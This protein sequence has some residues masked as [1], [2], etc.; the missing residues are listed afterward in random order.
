MCLVAYKTPYQH[1]MYKIV[2]R[3][4]R[5]YL[6]LLIHHHQVKICQKNIFCRVPAG[7]RSAVSVFVCSEVYLLVMQLNGA[8]V[9]RDVAKVA[10]ASEMLTASLLVLCKKEVNIQTLDFVISF[11]FISLT[12]YFF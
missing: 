12:L 1:M 6:S 4:F 5:C 9:P 8:R 11:P 7:K 2:R 10:F 3:Q